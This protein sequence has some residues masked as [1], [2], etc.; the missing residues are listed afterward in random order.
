MR[1]IFKLAQTWTL[2]PT[3]RDWNSEDAFQTSHFVLTEAGLH[4]IRVMPKGCEIFLLDTAA[5]NMKSVGFFSTSKIVGMIKP[6]WMANE[7]LFLTTSRQIHALDRNGDVHNFLPSV[8]ED[9]YLMPLALDREE[10]VFGLYHPPGDNPVGPSRTD[11]RELILFSKTDLKIKKIL[12][13]EIEKF[14]KRDT[15]NW[16]QLWSGSIYPAPTLYRWAVSE[17]IQQTCFEGNPTLLVE[18]FSPEKETVYANYY[19]ADWRSLPNL[20][21]WYEKGDFRIRISKIYSSPSGFAFIEY[22]E[23]N[24]TYEKV[25]L[26]VVYYRRKNGWKRYQFAPPKEE[27]EDWASGRYEILPFGDYLGCCDGPV[28]QMFS[29]SGEAGL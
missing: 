10:I 26:N 19:P 15:V 4:W 18:F 17:F 7:R 12:G 20:G 22:A 24:P 5:K 27:W 13:P 25:C 6:F 23:K 14:L 9:L 28:F 8:A 16:P 2:K 11:L 21:H 3:T 1:P 29:L